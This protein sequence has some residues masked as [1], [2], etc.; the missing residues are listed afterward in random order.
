MTRVR[1]VLRALLFASMLSPVV[2]AEGESSARSGT[3]RGFDSDAI[4][5]HRRGGIRVESV[6]TRVTAFEQD[7][8]GFQSQVGP[9]LGPGSEHAT[10]LEPVVEVVASQGER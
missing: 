8:H 4:L 1:G 7:G 5:G 6:M 3:G 2:R 9:L 10:I